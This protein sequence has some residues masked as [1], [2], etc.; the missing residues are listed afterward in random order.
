M[1]RVTANGIEIEY[2]SLGPDHAPVAL[3]IM[4]LGC[5]LIHWP[6]ALCEQLLAAGYRVVRF[7]NR[8]VGL[9]SRMEQA[10]IPKLLRAGIAARL[11]LP[12]RAPYGLEDLATDA[13]GLMDA[14]GISQAHV[15]GLSMGGMIAQL[16]AARHPQRL[17]SLTLWMTNSG[18]PGLPQPHW[19][20]QLR[21]IR[22]PDGRDRAA[23]VRHGVQT[24]Q[25]I[26]SPGYPT[27]VEHLQAQVERY[28]DRAHYPRG[29]ARQTAAILAA[30]HRRALLRQLRMPVQIIHGEADPLVP[31]AAAYDL[32]KQVPDSTLH[33]IPGMGHDIPPVLVPKLAGLLVEHFGKAEA[34]ASSRAA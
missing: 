11:R 9:S 24:W 26:G 18:H 4:G 29:T 2:E 10:G 34:A 17:R 7:D 15:V 19:R 30:R 13:L 32:A 33:V 8:D 5:Q 16:L 22:R 6:D 27:P 31:V 14:L 20:L 25:L 21:M 23:L 3:L 1:P 12:L 28:I